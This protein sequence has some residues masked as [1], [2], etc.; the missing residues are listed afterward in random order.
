[1]KFALC[2]LPILAVFFTE[3]GLAIAADGIEGIREDTPVTISSGIVGPDGSVILFDDSPTEEVARVSELNGAH[4]AE[5]KMVTNVTRS[6]DDDIDPN[7][8]LWVRK[9]SGGEKKSL[10]TTGGLRANPKKS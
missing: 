4:S 3:F 9:K 2:R 6:S 1:M 5:V 8:E 10:N 7:F